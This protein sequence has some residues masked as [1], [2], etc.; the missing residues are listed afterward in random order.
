LSLIY[1]W[2]GN[3]LPDFPQYL[4]SNEAVSLQHV[5]QSDIFYKF[6]L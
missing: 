5:S 1:A 2:F 4:T 3:Q 6:I